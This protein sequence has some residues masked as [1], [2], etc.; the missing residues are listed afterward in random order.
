MFKTAIAL[1]FLFGISFSVY[2]QNSGVIKVRKKTSRNLCLNGHTDG[3]IQPHLIC[4]GKGL[5]VTNSTQ[6]SIKNFVILIETVKEIEEL[7]PGNIIKGEICE[8]IEKLQT[9]DVI[10]INKINAIDNKTGKEV[11]LPSLR[12]QIVTENA[13]ER[14]KK[15]NM[16]NK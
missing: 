4:E 5:Y 8:T 1:L 9:G 15:Y 13:N 6:Y 3:A 10:Y 14:K 11:V 16:L 12:F 7:I 2:G